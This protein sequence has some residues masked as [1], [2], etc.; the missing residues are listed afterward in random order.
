MADAKKQAD[1]VVTAEQAPENDE[2]AEMLTK[3]KE[4]IHVPQVGETVTGLVV[5]ASKAEVRL[6]IDGTFIGPYD[7]SMSMGLPGQ[8][9]HPD[10][11]GAKKRVLD[12][13]RARGLAAGIHLVHPDR[14]ASDITATIAAGYQFIALGT[15]ILFLGD[16]CRALQRAAAIAARGR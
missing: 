8:L 9:D 6:D 5:S 4:G 13:T 15:D 11:A 16:S 14:A 12:A 2:F 10:I 7:L 3:E 1:L